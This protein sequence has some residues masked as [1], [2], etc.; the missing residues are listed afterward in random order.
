MDPF[1]GQI[2]LFAGNFTIREF[3]SCD[4]QIMSIAEHT[5]LFALLGTT[6]GGNGQTNFGLPDLRGRIPVGIGQGP[7][8]SAM[9]LGQTGGAER[10]TLTTPNMPAHNHPITAEVQVS[11]ANP[12]VR[13]P[14]ASYLTATGTEFYAA[15]ATANPGSSLGG[16]KSTSGLVGGN[17]PVS[18]MPP[19]LGLNYQIA[20][21]GIFPSRN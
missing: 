8:L 12:D 2:I 15:S 16:V 6:Y 11:V 5:A 18:T 17:Q 9:A 4:G 13:K 14:A 7:G 3:H 19:Y 21:S 20:L 1:I 10:V